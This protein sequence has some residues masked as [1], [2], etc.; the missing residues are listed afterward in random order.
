MTQHYKT[1]TD[2]FLKIKDFLSSQNMITMYRSSEWSKKK[3]YKYSIKWPGHWSIEKNKKKKVLKEYKTMSI[4]FFSTSPPIHNNLMHFFF[5]L[6]KWKI[7][8]R[9]ILKIYLMS[10]WKWLPSCYF[11]WFCVLWCEQHFRVGSFW[12]AIVILTNPA[13]KI[14]CS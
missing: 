4:F 2:Q 13:E 8:T 11:L 7:T 3:L 1:S 9:D 6:Q 5:V 12:H 14:M 10:S